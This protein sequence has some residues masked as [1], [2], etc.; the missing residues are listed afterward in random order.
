MQTE[1]NIQNRGDTDN[2][3]RRKRRKDEKVKKKKTQDYSGKAKLPPTVE[4][5][6]AD[7]EQSGSDT[8]KK[9]K[10]KENNS[11]YHSIIILQDLY[12]R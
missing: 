11:F 9:I 2:W 6:E 10:T 7:L 5:E 1:N 8:N 4:V 12:I 3:W